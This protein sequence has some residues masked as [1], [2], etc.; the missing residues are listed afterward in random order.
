MSSCR[1]ALRLLSVLAA[2]AALAGCIF[3]PEMRSRAIDIPQ[4]QRSLAPHLVGTWWQ[5]DEG[6]DR[7]DFR[8]V[9]I[10]QNRDRMLRFA[11]TERGNPD[12]ETST[13]DL[14]G[15]VILL[16][17]GQAG[18]DLLL[19]T[20]EESTAYMLA[21]QSRAGS[22]VMFPFLGGMDTALGDDRLGY[23]A[24][25]AA[26]H[27]IRLA[28]DK[29]SDAVILD[30]RL[31]RHALHALFSDTDFL[32]GLRLDPDDAVML[33][34]TSRP[35]PAPQ[36]RLAWWPL[37][38]NWQLVS[39]RF[40]IA[41][42][43]LVQPAGLSG[44]FREGNAAV[45]VTP[46]TDGSLL[47]ESAPDPESGYRREPRRIRLVDIGERD[48]LLALVEQDESSSE[49]RSPSAVFGY[50]M[51]SHGNDGSWSFAALNVLSQNLSR[52]LDEAGQA[53][54][55]QSVARHGLGLTLGRLTGQLDLAKVKA[56]LA[57]RQ[58]QA[59]LDGG[60]TPVW[61]DLAPVASAQP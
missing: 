3:P 1:P 54:R 32:G 20:A 23:L 39:D 48:R 55:A 41:S 28:R 12:D 40:P 33:L 14:D 36:D 58:F 61:F 2:C 30:G 18:V 19:F 57:D 47:V 44:P 4:A 5:F 52:P 56:L 59:G 60:A 26:R 17:G 45:T 38:F 10:R 51:A 27:G 21:V 31:D 34:P 7:N 49:G 50:L 43:E 13:D 16:R 53:I 42:T 22:L 6:G 37:A 15:K 46:Q 25:V 35:L 9:R 29:D 11:Y 8:I 24:S